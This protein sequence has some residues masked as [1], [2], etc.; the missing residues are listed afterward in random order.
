MTR[1]P[2]KLLRL[3]RA[4]LP[5]GTE[6]RHRRRLVLVVRVGNAPPRDPVSLEDRVHLLLT[7]DGHRNGSPHSQVVEGRLVLRQ[8]ETERRWHVLFLLPA[9]RGCGLW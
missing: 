6:L 3:R 9:G 5:P 2:Q 7:V 4:V 1:L 8:R